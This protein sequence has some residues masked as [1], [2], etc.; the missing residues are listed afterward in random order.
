MSRT[1]E[2][3]MNPI[4]RAVRLCKIEHKIRLFY[5]P[6]M[7]HS[8]SY[9]LVIPC[10]CLHC[11]KDSPSNPV[12]C[13]TSCSSAC[14]QHCY[15]AQTELDQLDR[16]HIALKNPVASNTVVNFI[17]V[18]IRVNPSNRYPEDNGALFWGQ[19]AMTSH[20]VAVSEYYCSK[21]DR[22]SSET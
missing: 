5:R 12:F 18:S 21:K 4:L 16:G 19:C 15:D 3:T 20:E 22:I 6:S 11:F 1:L 10:C 17:V 9:S 2:R 14:S 8:V 13:C 7:G